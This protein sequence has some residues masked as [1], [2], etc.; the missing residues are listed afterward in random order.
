M[1]GGG[2]GC[3]TAGGGIMYGN[4]LC[5]VG[6]AGTGALLGVGTGG[7]AGGKHGGTGKLCLI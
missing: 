6:V 1:T 3:G 2:G 5:P 7:G 4:V